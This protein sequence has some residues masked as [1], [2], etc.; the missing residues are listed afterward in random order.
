[1]K[2]ERKYLGAAI[3]FI[4]L[5]IIV[6]LRDINIDNQS[7]F[8][9][10]CDFAPTILA[11]AFLMKDEQ[12]VKGLINIGFI[13]QMLYFISLVAAFLG[14]DILGF[15]SLL[16]YGDSVLNYGLFNI[17]VGFL[18]HAFSSNVALLLTYKTKPQTK[19]LM[20]SLIVLAGMFI[21]GLFFTSPIDNVNYVFS[22]SALGFSIPFYTLLWIISSF[23]A[24]VLP[25]HLIQYALYKQSK[26]DEKRN[27]KKK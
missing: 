1:M 13:P 14:V 8:F 5:Q 22:S 27:H 3:F 17:A 26:D 6:I 24:L 12:L 19:S 11:F 20:Y 7:T 18:M 4:V 2:L 9:W 10:F 15:K 25:T 23:V 21:V 16:N